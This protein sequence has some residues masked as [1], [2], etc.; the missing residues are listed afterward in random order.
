[1]AFKARG[2]KFSDFPN[3]KPLMLTPEVIQSH[4]AGVQ[5]IGIYPL[6]VDNTSHF[7]AADFDKENWQRKALI[8]LKFVRNIKFRHAS[9]ALG[10]ESVLIY[11]FSLRK[12][13]WRK[14]QEPSC[15]NLLEKL[16]IFLSL[17]RK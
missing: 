11:G 2:G 14:N 8:F 7:I 9:N 4:L 13:I 5:T 1:M 12:N 17:K 6:L 10:R 15:L 16:S 3:K